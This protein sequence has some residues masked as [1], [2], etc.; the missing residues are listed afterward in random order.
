MQSGIRVRR[1]PLLVLGL[2][3]LLAGCTAVG[4]APSGP[5]LG[6]RDGGQADA[7]GAIVPTPGG[8]T[9]TATS[10]SPPL[11]ADDLGQLYQLV[12][13]TY[14]D[15]VDHS[16]LIDG[17]IAGIH[18]GA[19]ARG[20]LP[21]EAA[22]VETIPLRVSAD[23]ERDWLQFERAYDGLIG[24]LLRRV[25]V[26]DVGEAA[27]QG[28]LA[29]LGD[30]QT[31]YVDRGTV[32]A[33]ERRSYAGIGV[34]LTLQGDRGSPIVREVFAGSPAEAVGV[35]VGDTI[36]AV[37][38]R[39]TDGMSLGDSVQ[40]IRGAAGSSVTLRIQMPSDGRSTEVRVT[41]GALEL[42]IVQ[43]EW[44]DEVQYIRIRSFQEGVAKLIESR[45]DEAARDG[46]EGLILDLRGN[47]GGNLQEVAD[48]AALFVGDETIGIR[49]GRSHERTA[50]RATGRPVAPNMP[51][52][53]LVDRDTGSGAELLAAALRDR[54]DA[55]LLGTRTA[56]RAGVASVVPLANGA[57]AQITTQRM[58][59][60]TGE[61]LEGIG[62]QPNEWVDAGVDDWVQGRDPQLERA[63]S[64]LW[65]R[66]V[67]G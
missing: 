67:R 25:S 8:S 32:E 18:Q 53:V 50:I 22:V 13:D 9:S 38:G 2:A 63:L 60:S 65:G 45:L 10:A 7:P 14:V 34:S 12:I 47:S 51:L 37:D 64:E 58:L 28:M 57:V 5:R 41:R 15:R 33:Q 27:A 48:T 62:I 16:V 44:K 30:P 59:S 24:K 56:G 39:P 1:A 3:F 23:P 46:A 54:G 35:R 42:P 52:V 31:R 61:R 26:S 66:T 43:S 11:S 36:Q 17:A 20:L 19:V 6:R 4:G 49:M 40:A 21:V 29:A 55:R